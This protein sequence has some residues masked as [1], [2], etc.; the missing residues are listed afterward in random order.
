MLSECEEPS[1]LFDVIAPT[2]L[3]P[4]THIYLDWADI[5][6]ILYTTALITVLKK[7]WQ[8]LLLLILSA[9]CC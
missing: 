1:M 2:P 5:E 4:G 7:N 9:T 6:D 8:V 3:I